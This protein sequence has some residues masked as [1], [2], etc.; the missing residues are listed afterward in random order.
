MRRVVVSMRIPPQRTGNHSVSVNLSNH[1]LSARTNSFLTAKSV[2]LR[3]LPFGITYQNLICSSCALGSRL[4]TSHSAIL[5]RDR[6]LCVCGLLGLEPSAC[7][8]KQSALAFSVERS[9]LLSSKA[10]YL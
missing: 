7:L 4:L 10:D 8:D 1:K 2:R 9:S 5:H 3:G 6:R